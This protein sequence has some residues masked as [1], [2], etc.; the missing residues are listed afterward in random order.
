M[1]SPEIREPVQPVR[2]ASRSSDNEREPLLANE[3]TV[4]TKEDDD[5]INWR[6]YAFYGALAI[7]GT[8][9]LGLLIKGFIDSGDKD[10]SGRFG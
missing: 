10:V 9:V 5:N 1:S 3:S 2:T 6:W 8:V 4:P 7:V